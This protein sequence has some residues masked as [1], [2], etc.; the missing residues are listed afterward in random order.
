MPMAN[1]DE[2]DVQKKQYATVLD[3]QYNPAKV[4]YDLTSGKLVDIVNVIDRVSYLNKLYNS[5]PFDSAIIVVV[6]GD[7]IPFFVKK[8]QAKYDSIIQRMTSL[9]EGSNIEFRVCSAAAKVLN[10]ESRDFY[11]FVKMV[12]MADAEIVRLQ[13]EKGFAYMK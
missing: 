6:H 2:I 3:I 8:N 9:M 1:S 4:L 12:P 5:D 13:I 11:S 7:S 10:F